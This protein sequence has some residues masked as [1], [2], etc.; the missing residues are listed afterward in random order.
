M[1]TGELINYIKVQLNNGVSIEDIKNMLLTSG[2]SH[3][4]INDAL[5]K[6]SNLPSPAVIFNEAFVLYRQ[7]FFTLVGIITL[8]YLL[9]LWASTNIYNIHNLPFLVLLLIILLIFPTLGALALIIAIR[10][11]G[12]NIGIIEAYRSGIRK[13]FSF[14]VITTLLWLT[15]AG[16]LIFGIIP[17]II[18]IIWFSFSVYIYLDDDI[19]GMSALLKSREYVKGS[20]MAIFGRLL[21]IT[22]VYLGFSLIPHNIFSWTGIP[23]IDQIFSTV[24]YLLYTPLVTS[25]GYILYKSVRLIKGDLVFTT[26]KKAKRV[27]TFFAVIPVIISILLLS[28]SFLGIW[29]YLTGHGR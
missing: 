10:D 15:V 4:D 17:G 9:S 2:W 20:W 6:S 27:F 13:I 1:I 5:N 7:R 26:P 12:R 19:K 22:I 18:F 3:A 11:P 16:G 14:W 21:F 8:P 28:M 25:Y 29:F 24:L 23:Y